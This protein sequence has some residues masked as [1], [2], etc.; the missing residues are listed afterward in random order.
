[1]KVTIF[2]EYNPSMD[3]EEGRL[4]Y[5]QGMNACLKEFLSQRHDVKMIVHGKDDDGSE[6]SAEVLADT[7]VLIWWGHWY[8]GLVSDDVVNAVYEAVNRGTG[9][10]L[11]HSAHASKVAQRLLGTTG[12]LF[13][14]EGDR[15]RLWVIDRTHPIVKGIGDNIY[16]EPEEMYGEPYNAPAPD[17]QVFIS[18]F[19]GGEVLRSGNVYKRGLGK[20]FYFRPGHE[21]NPTYR[22]ESVQRV[23][24]NAVEYLAP[25]RELVRYESVH[26]EISPEE[27]LKR[28]KCSVR[29]SLTEQIDLSKK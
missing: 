28:N 23:I 15:E 5:P 20:I 3:N 25:D 27:R 26:A 13:W 24:F 10:I 22:N 29:R 17:E 7:D 14:R 18:W 21:T 16:L 2:T 6:L 9:L 19:G 11:L 12:T 8:H 1:M 4:A